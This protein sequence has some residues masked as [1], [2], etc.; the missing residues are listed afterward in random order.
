MADWI[1][2][3]V[4]TA[5]AW[6]STTGAIAWLDG[7]ARS[8]FRGTLIAATVVL[9]GGL[10][11]LAWLR[12][13]T[14]V[15]GAYLALAATLAVW[16]W[17]ELTFLMGAITGPRRS[18]CAPGCAGT[19]H[20]R[21]AVEAI[22][23][24]ELAIL[25]AAGAVV[26]ATWHGA[27]RVGFA[28]FMVLWVMRTSAK[29]NLFLGVRNLGEPFLPEHLRYLLSFFRRRPMNALF[30]FSVTGGTVVATGYALQAAAAPDEATQVGSVLIATL[31][32]LAVLEHW[33]MVVKLPS[34]RLWRWS[35][36]ARA[37]AS[38]A[39]GLA[40]DGSK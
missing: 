23:W 7:R 9:A 35:L 40:G 11:A 13:D 21:H 24:H 8:T 4:V 22:V 27:N 36:G 10:A 2:P 31:A 14:S 12:D 38:S 6:W 16:S 19:K 26:A 5:L 25:V 1:A 17:L 33:F 20:F 39:L 32:G 18:A 15:A 28:A 30:P 37:D 3:L 29:L 34:E